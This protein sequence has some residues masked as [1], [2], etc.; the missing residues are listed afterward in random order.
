M[1]GMVFKW[2]IFVSSY[3]P[4]FIMI[5][6]NN[7]SAFSGEKLKETWNLN[8]NFWII[9]VILSIVSFLSLKIWLYLL[10]RQADNDGKRRYKIDK[11]KPNDS[12][13]LNF[14]V[15]FIIPVISLKPN[16]APSILMNTLLLIIEGIYFVKNNSL[17]FNVLLIIMGYHIYSFGDDCI[18][19]TKKNKDD[20]IFEESEASQVGTTNIFYI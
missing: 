15:T 7:L 5:F 1:A 2:L 19:I 4:V 9:L 14:F 13:V 16:S 17:Y 11:I 8:A 6:L 10:K 12:E 3:I 18:I 20:L